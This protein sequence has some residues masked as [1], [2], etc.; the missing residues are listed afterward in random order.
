MRTHVHSVHTCTQYTQACTCA[1]A[2]THARA[3]TCT[4]AHTCI[5]AH[6]HKYARMHTHMYTLV[7]TPAHI[8]TCTHT[9]AHMHTHKLLPLTKLTWNFVMSPTLHLVNS[10][11][12]SYTRF[13]P[14]STL[15]RSLGQGAVSS[16]FYIISVSNSAYQKIDI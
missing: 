10:M 6:M 3:R 4:R 2:W 7:H 13:L 15:E 1:H 16:P 14:D 12:S 11:M 9:Y 8:H 5:H